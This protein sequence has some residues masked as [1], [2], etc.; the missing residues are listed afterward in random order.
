MEL[1]LDL[2]KTT[3]SSGPD[4]GAVTHP[5]R[6]LRVTEEQGRMTFRVAGDGGDLGET[7][8]VNVEQESEIRTR[9]LG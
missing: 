8:Q 4:A 2:S 9:G 7:K 1:V 3:G 5:A 6:R